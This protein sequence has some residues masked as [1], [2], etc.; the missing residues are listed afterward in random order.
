MG[1]LA[2][3]DKVHVLKE[4]MQGMDTVTDWA[5]GMRHYFGEGTYAREVFRDADSVIVSKIHRYSCINILLAGKM[6]VESEHENGTYEA[7][8][9]WVSPPGNERAIYYMTDCEFMTVH[10]NPTNTQDLGELERFLI[11]EN[12]EALED[13]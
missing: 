1:N 10:N 6:M 8:C 4:V 5:E 13:L 11:A 7:P 9:V 12:Y 2:T 3:R